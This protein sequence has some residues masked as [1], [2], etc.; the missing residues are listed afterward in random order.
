MNYKDVFIIL[1][2][3]FLLRSCSPIDIVVKQHEKPKQA[4]WEWYNDINE[5]VRVFLQGE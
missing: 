5:K 4:N 2:I 1:L 3:L